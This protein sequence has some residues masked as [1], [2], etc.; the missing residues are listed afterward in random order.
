MGDDIAPPDLAESIV[1][2]CRVTLGDSLR[3]VVFF[4]PDDAELLYLRS[5]LY[6]G[7]EE[8]A[9]TVKYAFVE[10]ERLGFTSQETYKELATQPLTEPDIGLYEFTIR[11]FSDGFVSRVIVGDHGVLLTTDSLDIASFE[12]KAVAIRKMLGT[13]YE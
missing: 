11:V 7:D 5:D 13:A 6:E 10:N 1:N 2:T 4:T 8:R 3:S 12:D 9:Q